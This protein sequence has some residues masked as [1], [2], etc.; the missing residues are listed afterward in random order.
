MALP[1]ALPDAQL[2]EVDGVEGVAQTPSA[3]R[4]AAEQEDSILAS[5][6]GDRS[7][8][9]FAPQRRQPGGHLCV[10]WGGEE[11]GGVCVVEW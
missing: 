8:V 2:G 5:N 10:E 9:A 6:A 4:G 1:C 7:G 11:V 3:C